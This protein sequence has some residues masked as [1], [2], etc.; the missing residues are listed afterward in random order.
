MQTEQSKTETL[1]AVALQPV[2][3]RAAGNFD[4]YTQEGEG[5]KCKTCGGD[6]MAARVHHPIWDG[7]FPCSGLGRVHVEEV[8]YCPT[9][10]EKPSSSG[11]PISA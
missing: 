7:P 2:V 3:R 10:E 6:I 11:S 5:W 9:C 8:P 1:A 4:N